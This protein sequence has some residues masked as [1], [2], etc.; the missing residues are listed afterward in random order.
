LRNVNGYFAVPWIN[1]HLAPTDKVFI[2]HRQLQYL[3][4]V[5]SFYGTFLYQSAVELRP[6]MTDSRTL[7][8]ELRSLGITHLLLSA[9]KEKGQAGYIEP[10]RLLDQAGCLERLKRWQGKGVK[11]RTLP[12]LASGAETLDLVR[13]GGERCLG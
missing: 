5:P 6:G 12:T 13:L 7:Y 9:G 10:Y 8:R 2:R 1:A 11:S 4:K 3:L